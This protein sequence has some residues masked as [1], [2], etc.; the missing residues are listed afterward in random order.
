MAVVK[1]LDGKAK[2]LVERQLGIAPRQP[3]LSTFSR[4]IPP[5]KRAFW[6]AFAAG[7]F[8]K[9]QPGFICTLYRASGDS[10]T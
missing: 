6:D 4:S 1:L 9:E 10:P 2:P 7:E 3:C 8:L 5:T